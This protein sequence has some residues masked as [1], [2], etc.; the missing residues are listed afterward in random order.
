MIFFGGNNNNNNN[1]NKT[2]KKTKINFNDLKMNICSMNNNFN[3][4]N[5]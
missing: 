1:N 5:K 2:Q 4:F 3:I